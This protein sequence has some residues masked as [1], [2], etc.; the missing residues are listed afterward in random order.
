[1]KFEVLV[2]ASKKMA[3]FWVFESSIIRAMME[4]AESTSET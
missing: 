3:V 2:A 1:V 4:E